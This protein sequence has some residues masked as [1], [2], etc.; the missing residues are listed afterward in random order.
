[1]SR[2]VMRVP[3]GFDAPIGK[4]WAPLLLPEELVYPA[5]T[6]CLG[7]GTTATHDWLHSIAWLI[8]MLADD[9]QEQARGRDIHPYLGD[10]LN[11]PYT[12]VGPRGER[13]AVQ[14]RP[15]ADAR[16]LVLGLTGREPDQFFGYGGSEAYAVMKAIIEAAG[17]NPET[18]GR[19]PTCSGEGST[20]TAELRAAHEAWSPAEVPVG[21]GW[22]LWQ[23]VSE[24]GPVS[25]AFET[26]EALAWWMSQ[27]DCL[28]SGQPPTYEAALKFVGDGWA[29][30]MMGSAETGVV[31]G[32][33]FA[34]RDVGPD[35]ALVLAAAI[36][37]GAA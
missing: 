36:A 14:P 12:Y 10:L 9:I 3:L 21:E 19:C 24:G 22:Q 7:T 5:C 8:P 15:S 33:T 13:R 2:E 28:S 31:D 23:T 27:N 32:I 29:P 20:P 16:E 18:W 6:T 37:G 25:P 11:R 26:G 35:D 17:L 4:T 34:A 30:S 1:M